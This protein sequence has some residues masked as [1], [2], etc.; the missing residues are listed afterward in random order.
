[1]LKNKWLIIFLSI[2]SVWLLISVYYYFQHRVSV[3]IMDIPGWT[4]D[5][6]SSLGLQVNQIR[7]YDWEEKERDPSKL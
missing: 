3:Q 1:M 5:E 2:F 7:I 4:L 6:E